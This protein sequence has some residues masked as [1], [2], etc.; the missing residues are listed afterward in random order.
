MDRQVKLNNKIKVRKYLNIRMHELPLPFVEETCCFEGVS[1]S[2]LRQ[3]SSYFQRCEIFLSCT[4]ARQK[5]HVRFT[6]KCMLYSL[7]QLLIKVRNKIKHRQKVQ[8]REISST[9]G[10]LR[11]PRVSEISLSCTFA[12]ARFYISSDT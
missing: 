10:C 12:G 1:F 3:T 6:G 9:L 8:D 4:S 5:N 11:H 2:L 7:C